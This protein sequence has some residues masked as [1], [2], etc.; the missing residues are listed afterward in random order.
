VLGCFG[1]GWGSRH[2]HIDLEPNEFSRKG[3]KAFD[4]VA[5][6]S[7]LDDDVLAVDVAE[8]A[9]PL[10]ECAPDMPGLWARHRSATEYADSK[11]LRL[12]LRLGD[13]RRGKEAAR[14]NF[15]ECSPIYH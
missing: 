10:E 11:D 3:G 14:D 12:Q 6:I 9:Q 1:C 8:L 5:V 4:I 2:D 15:K 13:H 7:T